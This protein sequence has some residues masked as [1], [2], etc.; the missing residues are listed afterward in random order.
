MPL[1]KRKVTIVRDLAIQTMTRKEINIE[2]L[3]KVKKAKIKI[4]A[5]FSKI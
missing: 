5:T 4:E 1:L 3:S 2:E